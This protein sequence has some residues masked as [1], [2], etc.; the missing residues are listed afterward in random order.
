MLAG[1][2]EPL[3]R[4][5]GRRAA[6]QSQRHQRPLLGRSAR[7]HPVQHFG[8]R[9]GVGLPYLVPQLVAQPIETLQRPLQL[10]GSAGLIISSRFS[11]NLFMNLL[12]HRA[13][14]W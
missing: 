1:R 13:V 4:R 2:I 11:F 12:V 7:I 10:A 6:Q 5:L 14:S 3:Q 8:H 9:R